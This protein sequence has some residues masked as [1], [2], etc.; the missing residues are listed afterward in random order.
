[1]FRVSKEREREGESPFFFRLFW[2]F[3]PSFLVSIISSVGV[4]SR[5][6]HCDLVLHY[7]FNFFRPDVYDLT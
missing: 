4:T 3:F 6:V 1:M 2:N 5:E 7:L